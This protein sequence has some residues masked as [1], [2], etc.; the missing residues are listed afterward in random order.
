MLKPMTERAARVTLV[1]ALI[2]GLGVRIW[3][4]DG[5]V[6]PEGTSRAVKDPIALLQHRLDQ[7][8]VTLDFD[9][10]TGYLSSVLK[11][12]CIPVS[13]QVLVFSKTSLQLRRV[14]PTS[15]RAIYY[16]DDA[17]I[18]WLPGSAVLEVSSVHPQKGALFYTLI[19]RPTPKPQFTHQLYECTSCHDSRLTDGVPGHALRS[20]YPAADG[21]PIFRGGTFLT[22]HGS[23]F[24]ER[25]G[26][27]YVTGTIDGARHMGNM[28]YSIDDS[29]S[30]LSSKPVGRP[31]ELSS[32]VDLDRYLS[33]QSDI[34]ALMVLD[35]QAKMHNLLT[36]A[37][38]ETRR[39]LRYRKFSDEPAAAGSEGLLSPAAARRIRFVA[40]TLLKYLLF[41][42]ETPLPGI[43]HGSS[44]F[45]E[46]FSQGEPRDS[47]GRSLRDLDLKTRLFEY[48]CSYLIYSDAFVTLPEEVK[49][50]VLRRLWEVLT[51][52]DTSGDFVR[53]S[54]TERREILAIL[55][56]TLP[57]LP[58]Y[59]KPPS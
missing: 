38:A 50:I 22:D 54:R 59:W 41:V 32:A 29:V 21:R 19:Q 5:L 35:H 7:G 24:R 40:K 15:P 18:A 39:V 34:V 23:A 28:V 27:W 26:G 8:V 12:L 1:V 11:A 56:E 42:D 14:S 48:S 30:P 9:E 52:R 4:E 17:Y 31:T 3:A 53:L 20:V 33:P 58:P 13:S 49:E 47:K 10:R 44:S 46:D 25:W 16:N 6:G 36:W 2:S 37:R 45:A 51:D 43:V 55:T 57:D